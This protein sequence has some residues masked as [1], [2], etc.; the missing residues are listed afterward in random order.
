[1]NATTGSAQPK[2]FLDYEKSLACVHCGLCLSACPT[3]LETGNENDSPRGRIYLMRAFQ[4]GRMPLADT[5][6]S[7]IDLCL[8][9]RACEVACPSG[10]QYGEL[11]EAT[12]DHIEKEYPRGFFQTLLRRVVIEKVFPFPARTKLALMPARFA[13]AI[14]IEKMLPKFLRESLSL[15]PDHCSSGK[16]LELYPTNLKPAKG[17]IGFIRGC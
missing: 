11:L 5:A 1:M 9:C 15:V 8:G 4:D 17:K 3:Y 6:V 16:L 12:R 7:H 10:V 14:G 13:K 2:P